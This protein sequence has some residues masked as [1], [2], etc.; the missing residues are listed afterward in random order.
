M[1]GNSIKSDILPILA[2]GGSGVHVPYRITWHHEHSE[3]PPASEGRF[4]EAES[5]LDHPEIVERWLGVP[6]N[7]VD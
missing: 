4:F 2:L 3:K 5:L 6:G 7:Q 1:V